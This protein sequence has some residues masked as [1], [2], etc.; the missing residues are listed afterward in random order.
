MEYKSIF[1]I[2]IIIFLFFGSGT[3]WCANKYVTIEKHGEK[4]IKFMHLISLV[5]ISI[6]L[7][8]INYTYINWT[9]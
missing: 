1:I 5:S 3:L 2:G 8:M 6:G 9:E 4:M 7:Y